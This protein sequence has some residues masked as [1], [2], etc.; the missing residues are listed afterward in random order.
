LIDEVSL[1][2]KIN[3]FDALDTYSRTLLKNKVDKLEN[4]ITDFGGKIDT[5]YD[6]L[7]AL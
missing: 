3:K 7:N 2:D 5:T 4:L 6:K 1:R